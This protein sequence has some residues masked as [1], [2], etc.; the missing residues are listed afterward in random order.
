VQLALVSHTL[1][2]LGFPRLLG[3]AIDWWTFLD[4]LLPSVER[5][6]YQLL[7]IA[8]PRKG[9]ALALLQLAYNRDNLSPNKSQNQNRAGRPFGPPRGAAHGCSPRYSG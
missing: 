6:R 9:R 5:M 4:T 1:V 3:L 7:R 8:V 2:C